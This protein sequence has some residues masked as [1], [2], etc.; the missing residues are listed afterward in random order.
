MNDPLIVGMLGMAGMFL[1]IALPVPIG[2]AMGIA[3][4]LAF[5]A[6]HGARPALSPLGT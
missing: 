6:N 1:L 5:A 3:G 4:F 2:V